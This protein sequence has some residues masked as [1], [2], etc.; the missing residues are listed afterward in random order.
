MA[1]D[2]KV[3][4]TKTS[5]P[6]VMIGVLSLS[7]GL[8]VLMLFIDTT[9]GSGEAPTKAQT[10]R[11]I[12]RSYIAQEPPLEEYQLLLRQAL[13]AHTRGDTVRERR[14][15]RRVLDMLHAEGKN[16]FKGLTGVPDADQPPNDR[17]LE[18]LLS[19]ML[20]EDR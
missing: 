18:E 14:I 4:K 9:P 17:D 12:E 1:V 19:T 6:W 3:E 11:L 20:A 13:Q 10:R 5:N 16:K 7:F 15:Y 8:S 2:T